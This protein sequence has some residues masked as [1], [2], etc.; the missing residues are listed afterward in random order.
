MAK[1][2]NGYAFGFQALGFLTFRKEGDYKKA[3]DDYRI[4]LEEYSYNKIWS[5]LSNGD[6]K[7][8]F[9]IANSA[10]G[11]MRDILESC[12]VDFNHFNTYRKR[13]IDKGVLV[14]K[15]R[16]VLSFVLPLF[17]EYIRLLFGRQ[18]LKL[19]NQKNIRV[20]WLR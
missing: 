8:L 10:S 13:L 7:V 11:R 12:N 3:L 6:K 19:K 1:L 20:R 14:E 9:G 16:G 15:G 2:T 18:R 4:Y 5:E 17:K